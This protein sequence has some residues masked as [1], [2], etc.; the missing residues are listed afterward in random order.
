MKIESQ[1]VRQRP[2]SKQPVSP[3]NRLLCDTFYNDQTNTFTGLLPPTRLDEL[4]SERSEKAR[5]PAKQ[6]SPKR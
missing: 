4:D 5:A 3:S 2:P 1:L 6:G